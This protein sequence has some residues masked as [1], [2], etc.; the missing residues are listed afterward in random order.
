MQFS[1]YKNQPFQSTTI[2]GRPDPF[3][4]P[5]ASRKDT[6][7]LQAI[8]ADRDG[9]KTTTFKFQSM[10]S[11]SMNLATND[12]EGKLSNSVSSQTVI[13]A[14]PKVHGS[15]P[16]GNKLPWNLSNLDIERSSPRALHVGLSK[17]EN[18]MRTEDILGAKPQCVK[19]QTTRL[20][21]NPLNPKYKL[22]TAI[23]LP[24]EP[25]RFVRDQMSI[26]DIEGAKPSRKKHVDIQ[27][28]NNMDITDIDGA[29]P[30]YGHEI[31]ERKEGF[32]KSY[33]YNPMDYRD[34]THTE[35]KSTRDVNPLMPTYIVRNDAN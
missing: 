18:N 8:D 20:D 35:F 23:Y 3:N 1:E 19:F 34:V 33:N 24:P 30:K 17:Q 26:D 2:G 32:G 7:N 16:I 13:G 6:M 25:M 27:T 15:K 21:T 31:K 11:S 29:K 5:M 10:R 4:Y 22:Q 14:S 28:R 9:M 12:I